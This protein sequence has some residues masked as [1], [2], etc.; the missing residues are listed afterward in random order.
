MRTWNLTVLAVAAIGVGAGVIGGGLVSRIAAPWAPLASTAVLWAGMLAA[1]G[2]AFTRGRPAGLLRFR[3]I[4]LLWGVGFG[5]GLRLLQGWL[6]GADAG[7]F[8]SAATLDGSLPTT[9]WLTEALPAA[10]VAPPVEE[11]FFRAVILVTVYQL[12]RRSAGGFAAGVAA[13]LVSS[14]GFVLLHAMG[15]SLSVADAVQL[16]AVG[17]TGGLL[18]LLTGRIWG[19]V[20]THVVYNASYLALV[21][22]GTLLS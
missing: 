17:G 4:D 22:A 5:L 10:V 16:L 20:L 13:L 1:V 12:L 11:F 19:A 21:A 6:S 9:W 2:F 3:A 14:G 7:A 8:P 15:G 18:V